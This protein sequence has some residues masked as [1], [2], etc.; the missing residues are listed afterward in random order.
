MTVFKN[1][2][3]FHKSRFKYCILTRRSIVFYVIVL[4]CVYI[5]IY[6]NCCIRLILVN[7]FMDQNKLLYISKIILLVLSG[8]IG[9]RERFLSTN[10][11]G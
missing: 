8:F 1:T 10:S 11:E 9:E 2:L 6:F 4:I 3:H 7:F 5:H